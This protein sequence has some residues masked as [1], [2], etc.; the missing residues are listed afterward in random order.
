MNSMV[1]IQIPG[2]QELLIIALYVVII[3]AALYIG[4]NVIIALKQL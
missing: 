1:F 2:V 3:F 4:R